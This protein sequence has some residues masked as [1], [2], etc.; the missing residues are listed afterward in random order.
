VTRTATVRTVEQTHLLALDRDPFLLSVTGHVDSHHAGL[1]V[2]G[3]FLQNSQ[4]LEQA[5]A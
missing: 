4:A 2:A 5:G 1:E 3:R